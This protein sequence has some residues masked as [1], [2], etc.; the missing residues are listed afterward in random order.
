MFM[1]LYRLQISPDE[2]A[3]CPTRLDTLVMSLAR[4]TSTHRYRDGITTIRANRQVL[5]S[6]S[7][8]VD[9]QT[10][11]EANASDF[12]PAVMMTSMIPVTLY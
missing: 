5:E 12:T 2:L 10:R 11:L 4:Y 3:I 8:L 9:F 6:C 1:G 7:L